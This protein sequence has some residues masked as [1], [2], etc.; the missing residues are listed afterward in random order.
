MRQEFHKSYA[1]VYVG[2]KMFAH[3]KCISIGVRVQG[4]P[5]CPLAFG[6]PHRHLQVFMDCICIVSRGGKYDE[7]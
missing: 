5:A 6:I 2:H 1:E 3:L 7:M 4:L